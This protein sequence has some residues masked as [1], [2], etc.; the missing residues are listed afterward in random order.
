MLRKSPL[1][2]QMSAVA[3]LKN[4]LYLMNNCNCCCEIVKLKN[5][6]IGKCFRVFITVL[7]KRKLLQLVLW[8]K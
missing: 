8:I 3:L 2:V 7:F 5:E 4:L 1:Q 6:R